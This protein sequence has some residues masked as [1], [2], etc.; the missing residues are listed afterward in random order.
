[1]RAAQTL[2]E[3]IKSMMPITI[4]GM[5][6]HWARR[7]SSSCARTNSIRYVRP[8]GL[9][10]APLARTGASPRSE[11]LSAAHSAVGGH[12][13]PPHG[14]PRAH[15]RRCAP[16]ACAGR[17]WASGAATA[18]PCVPP[19]APRG[20]MTYF[21]RTLS[22]GAADVDGRLVCAVAACARPR[23]GRPVASGAGAACGPAGAG[24]GG[25]GASWRRLRRVGRCPRLPVG[26]R[27]RCKSN[28]LYAGGV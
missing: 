14:L 24:C 25:R 7:S 8:G 26:S 10:R 19:K 9:E 4:G 5:S 12:A 27:E 28:F 2:C 11:A 6:L 18:R 1:M 22:H 3:P 16:P 17:L 13:K 15:R 20:A 23:G 21:C